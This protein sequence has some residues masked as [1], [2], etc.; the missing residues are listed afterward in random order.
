[1]GLA[2]SGRS[3]VW[4]GLHSSTY[5][6]SCIEGAPDLASFID[7]AA[8]MGVGGVELDL[9]ELQHL[10]YQELNDLRNHLSRRNLHLVLDDTRSALLGTGEDKPFVTGIANRI[11]IAQ[12]LGARVLCLRADVAGD[13]G[14]A[15]RAESIRRVIRMLQHLIPAIEETGLVLGLDTVQGLTLAETERILQAVASPRLGLT[16]TISNRLPF[17]REA[18]DAAL[19]LAP[20]IQNARITGQP[21]SNDREAVDN[22]FDSTKIV[23]L[24]Q[25]TGRSMQ[26]AIATASTAETP[27]VEAVDRSGRTELREYLAFLQQTSGRTPAMQIPA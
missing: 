16:L 2:F 4:L 27:T 3:A 10:D 11:Q 13:P 17:S 14:S 5:N 19:A 20:F 6:G 12:F 1:M 21:A 22:A 23:E 7:W 24:L 26:I 8:A 25:A 18:Y 15:E 9:A